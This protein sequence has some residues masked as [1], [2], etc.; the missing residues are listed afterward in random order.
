MQNTV[1]NV[2]KSPS[3]SYSGC[4]FWS[5]FCKQGSTSWN[6]SSWTRPCKVCTSKLSTSS[7]NLRL[8]LQTRSR[9]T[10]SHETWP[11]QSRKKSTAT[12]IEKPLCQLEQMY[13]KEWLQNRVVSRLTLRDVFFSKTI[14]AYVYHHF[15]SH[16]Y[17]YMCTC[18]YAYTETYLYIYIYTYR[19]IYIY[20]Y[21]DPWPQSVFCVHSEIWSTWTKLCA[22]IMT[23]NH[24][25]TQR[26]RTKKTTPAFKKT[27]QT[28]CHVKTAQICF[29]FLGF[30]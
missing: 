28:W 27:T 1:Q 29:L 18:I 17:V 9:D 22:R 20:I 12:F 5:R 19:Y 3:L 7:P 4:M 8:A 6:A 16:K 11:R 26:E 2:F 13:D 15:C 10:T 25:E 21:L 14:P 30:A 23:L 24:L